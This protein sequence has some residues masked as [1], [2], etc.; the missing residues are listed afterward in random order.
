MSVKVAVYLVVTPYRKIEK[1]RSVNV[2]LKVAI[3]HLCDLFTQAKCFLFTD[4]VSAERD[5]Y[6]N[7]IKRKDHR[8][9]IVIHIYNCRSVKMFVG[10]RV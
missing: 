7:Y 6:Y 5:V 9:G 2:V 3:C 10:D 4:G 1:I 8:N